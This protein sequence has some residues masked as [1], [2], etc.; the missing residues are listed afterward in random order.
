MPR[1]PSGLS[2]RR[3]ETSAAV[4]D[5][6]RCALGPGFGPG[7]GGLGS[8]TEA[9]GVGEAGGWAPRDAHGPGRSIPGRGITARYGTPPGLSQ[10]QTERNRGWWRKGDPRTGSRCPITT[11]Y[12]GGSG[13][14]LLTA[15][16]HERRRALAGRSPCGRLAGARG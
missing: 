14:A 13:G 7:P 3:H 2:P 4:P 16:S 1:L 6:A 8:R 15:G 12:V 9:A 5:G 11:R 10:V